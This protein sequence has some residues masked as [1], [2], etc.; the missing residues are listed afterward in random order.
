TV[1]IGNGSVAGAAL[2]L[3]S[4][5]MRRKAEK[6]AQTMTYYDLTTDPSFMEEYS[7]ALYLPGSK[8]LFPSRS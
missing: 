6:I 7:A 3:L 1:R 8:E 4:T 5:E 2:A